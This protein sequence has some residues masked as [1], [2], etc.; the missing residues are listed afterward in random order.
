MDATNKEMKSI[1]ISGK[2]LNKIPEDVWEQTSLESIIIGSGNNI[3]ASEKYKLLD[4]IPTIKKIDEQD[5]STMRHGIDNLVEIFTR[6]LE[7]LFL[8]KAASAIY[9][10]EISE[11]V[12]IKKM[13]ELAKTT[14]KAG[15][16]ALM[17]FKDY[18]L[19]KMIRENYEVYVSQALEKSMK[20]KTDK[21]NYAPPSKKS[22]KGTKGKGKTSKNTGNQSKLTLSYLLQTHSKNNDPKDTKTKV[23]MCEFE[24]NAEQPG[25]TTNIVAT[26]GGDSICFIDCDTGMAIKKYKEIGEEF[27]CIC[28]TVIRFK[29]ELTGFDRKVSMLAAA[30]V[31]GDIKLIDTFNLVCFKS[32]SHHKKPVD[33][34]L[35]HPVEQ[36][37][38]FSGS[39]DKTIV[40]WDLGIPFSTDNRAAKKLLTLRAS[41]SGTVRQIAILPHGKVMLGA[42]DDGLHAWNVE[43]IS[44]GVRNPTYKFHFTKNQLQPL[45]SA[46]CLTNDLLAV[47]RVEEGL[48]HIFHS[49]SEFLENDFSIIYSLT[50]RLTETPFLKFNFNP[51]TSTLT[52]GDD[53]GTIW[54]YYLDELIA[55]SNAKKNIN[56]FSLPSAE[57]LKCDN[58]LA[59]IFNHVTT[60]SDNSHVVGVSDNNVVAIW[61]K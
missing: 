48:I 58:K 53:E 7:E 19:E 34:L 54:M 5:I 57:R 52:A 50:W 37:W 59:K 32:V 30:G 11:E 31:K 35:F 33:A 28:W 21:E 26:C 61:K 60:S 56:G 4:T 42:C 45:D 8:T 14:I 15:P 6:R 40:L 47:K 38:M 36:N 23:W 20:I 46:N 18:K 39:E 44:N 25:K 43:N 16:D 29:N 51:D 3:Q 1:D 2:G 13:V 12:R 17:D 27:Y 41:S 49:S 55:A 10:E 22:K 24:P 9:C